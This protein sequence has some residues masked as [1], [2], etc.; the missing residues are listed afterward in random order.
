MHNPKKTTAT[1]KKIWIDLDNSPH[2]PFFSPIIRRLREAGYEVMITA[3]DCFQVCGLADLHQIRYQRIGVHYGKNKMMKIA[4]LLIRSVQLTPAVLREKPHIAVSHGSRSQLVVTQVFGIP[5][6]LIMDYEF[7]QMI[8]NPSWIIM[9]EVIPDRDIHFKSERIIRYPGIKEDVYVPDF[10]PDS[11]ILDELGIRGE[12]LIATVRPPA[13]EAHYHNPES[14][15]L[16]FEV[17]EYLGRCD[18]VRVVVLP[19]N[20]KQ[21]IQ[22]QKKWPELCNCRKTVIPRKVVN[23]LNLIWHSDFVISGGGTI[24]REAAALGVPVYSIFRGK[25]GAVDD[26]LSRQGRLHLIRNKED[27]IKNIPLV[28]RRRHPRPEYPERKALDAVLSAILSITEG[29]YE[30]R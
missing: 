29:G 16:F 13:T 17:I 24:N 6:I 8:A 15:S 30:T 11:G 1:K 9:P 12:D 27:V 22:I 19:R 5:S 25:L 28:R 23:G 21:E 2:V 26:Y 10:K 4:G 3:R 14:E 20:E 7:S 18:N